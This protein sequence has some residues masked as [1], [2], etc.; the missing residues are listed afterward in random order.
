MNSS[1]YCLFS[2]KTL[3]LADLAPRKRPVVSRGPRIL[4]TQDEMDALD[5]LLASEH[6]GDSVATLCRKLPHLNEGHIRNS[7]KR[8]ALIAR[9]AKDAEQREID[10]KLIPVFVAYVEARMVDEQKVA[11]FDRGDFL[12]WAS[13]MGKEEMQYSTALSL[14]DR[15]L[16]DGVI[17]KVGLS[18]YTFYRKEINA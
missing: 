17:K 1:A 16:E 14:F 11:L 2:G 10:R 9:N 13:D 5:H 4:Q 12:R 18:V 15:L 7:W 3:S 6:K 8:L